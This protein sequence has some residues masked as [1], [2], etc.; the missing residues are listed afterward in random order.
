MIRLTGWEDQPVYVNP[1]DIAAIEPYS[2]TES[3]I[4]AKLVAPELTAP[5]GSVV[6]L[7]A[8]RTLCV[9]EDSSTIHDKVV[10]ATSSVRVVS[11]RGSGG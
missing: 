3:W 2:T 1:F 4:S 11:E 6:T 8:G 9:S 7:S 5:T 10:E